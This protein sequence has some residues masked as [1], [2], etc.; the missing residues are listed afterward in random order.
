MSFDLSLSHFE[1][2]VLL[3][4]ELQLIH[5]LFLDFLVVPGDLSQLI[6]LTLRKLLQFMQ[7]ILQLY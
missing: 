4:V 2:D 5:M 3:C 7:L 6:C 1:L